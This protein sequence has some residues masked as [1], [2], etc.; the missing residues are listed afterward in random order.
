MSKKVYLIR[1]RHCTYS[2]GTEFT[3]AQIERLKKELTEDGRSGRDFV[4][5]VT[6]SKAKA[7]RS[8]KN[9]QKLCSAY[10]RD[11]SKYA[12]K[13]GLKTTYYLTVYDYYIEMRYA[14]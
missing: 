5:E 1:S 13:N 3:E 14:L 6:L 4:Q 10:S 11:D 7:E 2:K 9:Y 8:L 12:K